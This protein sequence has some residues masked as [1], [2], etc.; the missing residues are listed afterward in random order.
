MSTVMLDALDDVAKLI[1][2]L[3]NGRTDAEVITT[4]RAIERALQRGGMSLH[5]LAR[6]LSGRVP[7]RPRAAAETP[8]AGPVPGWRGASFDAS[9]AALETMVAALADREDLPGETYR[10]VRYVAGRLASG[11][12]VSGALRGQI[13]AMYRVYVSGGL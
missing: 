11:K 3:G 12:P 1:P 4:A 8:P 2:S 13:A 9:A 10:T 7:T 6:Q 5:D